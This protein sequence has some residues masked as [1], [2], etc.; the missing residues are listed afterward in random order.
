VLPIIRK[1]FIF[2][3]GVSLILFGMLLLVTPGPGLLVIPAG[4]AVLALEFPWAQ[5]C[6]ARLEAFGMWCKKKWEDRK[7]SRKEK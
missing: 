1:T 2:I 4:F 6:W 7:L 3:A 5:R